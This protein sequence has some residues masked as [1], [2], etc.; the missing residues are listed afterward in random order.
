M[1]STSAGRPRAEEGER[2]VQ[3]PRRHDARVRSA[4]ELCGLP[5]GQALDGVVRERQGDEEA[6]SLMPLHATAEEI[7][8]VCHG[9]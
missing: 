4:V 3:V 8:R 1:R 5:G 2:D 7:A 6:E 9:R